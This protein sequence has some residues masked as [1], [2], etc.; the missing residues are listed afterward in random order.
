MN[1]LLD[2]AG[3]RIGDRE[4]RLETLSLLI[5]TAAPAGRLVAVLRLAREIAAGVAVGM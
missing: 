3:E 1:G 5:G 2:L 4:V